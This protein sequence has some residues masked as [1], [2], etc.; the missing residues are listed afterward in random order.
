ML[1]ICCISTNVQAQQEATYQRFQYQKLHWRAYHA[2]QFSIYFPANA[3]DSLYRF[4]AVEMPQAMERIRKATLKEVPA[5]I[6][7]IIYP[8]VSKVYE[9][10][11]GMYE[12]GKYPYPVFANRGKRVV[13]SFNGSYTDLKADLDEALVRAMWESQVKG[14]EGVE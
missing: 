10:N 8:S 6:N 5:N 9:S 1:L 7:V 14:G 13:I 12:P 2:K 4:V 3:A 11:I